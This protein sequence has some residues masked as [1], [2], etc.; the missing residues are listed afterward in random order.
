MLAAAAQQ[1]GC[2]LEA[3]DSNG[4]LPVAAAARAIPLAHGFRAHLQ[5]SL[6][7]QLREWPER[8]PLERLPSTKKATIAAD[9]LSRWPAASSAVLRG[10]TLSSLPIDHSALCAALR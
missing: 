3:V 1:A 8:R 6:R 2:A 5:R 4:V 10:D 9:I 7:E